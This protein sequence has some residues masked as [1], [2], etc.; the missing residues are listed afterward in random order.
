[1]TRCKEKQHKWG[2]EGRENGE[3]EEEE[4][5]DGPCSVWKG[6]VISLAT[7]TK[8]TLVYLVPKTSAI[9]CERG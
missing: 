5:V 8:P 7:T 2:R 9:V 4:G 1:M 3:E 6:R